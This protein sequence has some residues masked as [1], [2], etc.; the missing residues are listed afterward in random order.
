MAMAAELVE[1]EDPVLRAQI[2][3]ARGGLRRA[4]GRYGEAERLLRD[5]LVR[6]ETALGSST[7]EV[8]A[9]LCELGVT[10]KYG[11][12]FAGAERLYGLTAE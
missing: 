7:Y 11:G 6:A 3:R 8:A 4:Q 12:N 1:N 10:F 2:S 9:I 5:A